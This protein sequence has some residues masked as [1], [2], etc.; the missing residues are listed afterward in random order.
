MESIVREV[1]RFCDSLEEITIPLK[2][3]VIDSDTFLCCE[4]PRRVKF[5]E[6]V[7][8]KEIINA[9]LVDEWRNEM[10]CIR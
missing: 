2:N 3:G 1:F 7:V 4:T 10:N 5:A 8:L 9:F 6:A